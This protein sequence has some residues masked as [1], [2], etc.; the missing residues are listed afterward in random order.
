MPTNRDHIPIRKLKRDVLALLRDETFDNAMDAIGRMPAR[1]V[2]N[3]LFSFLYSL[4]ETVKGAYN[5]VFGWWES[6]F[7]AG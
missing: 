2:I 1:P 6:D 3:P 7:Q 4:D 5:C